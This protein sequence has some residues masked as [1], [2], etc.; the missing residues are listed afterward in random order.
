MKNK[1]YAKVGTVRKKVAPTMNKPLKERT[2]IKEEFNSKE[3][4]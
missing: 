4:V 1:Q 2:L 3:A